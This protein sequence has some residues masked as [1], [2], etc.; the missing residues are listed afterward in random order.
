[1]KPSLSTENANQVRN[2]STQNGLII[3]INSSGINY[4][5]YHLKHK[6]IYDNKNNNNNNKNQKKRKIKLL[7]YSL[8]IVTLFK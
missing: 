6:Q 5:S 1:M 8:L 3:Q 2:N 7:I 4:S